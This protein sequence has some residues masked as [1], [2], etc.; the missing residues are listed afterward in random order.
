MQQFYMFIL[1]FKIKFV[2]YVFTVTPT[3]ESPG[4]RKAAGPLKSRQVILEPAMAR[5][6]LGANCKDW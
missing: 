6:G 3:Y 2:Y 5:R 4:N 1:L